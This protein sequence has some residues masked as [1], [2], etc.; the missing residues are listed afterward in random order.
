MTALGRS[1]ASDKV[2]PPRAGGVQPPRS[3]PKVVALPHARAVLAAAA[4]VA[5]GGG[6]LPALGAPRRAVLAHVAG[7][8][9]PE[10]QPCAAPHTTQH[11]TRVSGLAVGWRGRQCVWLAAL[12]CTHG[13]GRRVPRGRT[14]RTC[15]R[16]C[17]ARRWCTCSSSGPSAPA[18]HTH[19]MHHADVL[20]IGNVRRCGSTGAAPPL[21]LAPAPARVRCCSPA[22]SGSSAWWRARARR[23]PRQS[24]GEGA[25]GAAAPRSARCRRHCRQSARPVGAPVGALRCGPRDAWS[26][27]RR[28]PCAPRRGAPGR[29]RRRSQSCWRPAQRPAR[30]RRRPAAPPRPCRRP[31]PG[32][33]W[34]PWPCA[35]AWL[36]VG[37]ACAA[38]VRHRPRPAQPPPQEHACGSARLAAAEGPRRSRPRPP[39]P[40][41]RLL[42][43]P[44]WVLQ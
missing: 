27:R 25:P 1:A 21:S 8:P 6:A 13:W 4:A 39:R 34:R 9:T 16:A 29:R 44:L 22:R 3:S 19:H 42:A 24:S 20:A 11:N 28:A 36:A 2:P 5:H 40:A 43:P 31:G 41:A 10:A 18:R 7:A 23:R 12:V 37:R 26:A 17:P 15:G 33:A 38:E 14:G 30:R 32:P 35:S